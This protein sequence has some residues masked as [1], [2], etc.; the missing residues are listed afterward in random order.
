M[1]ISVVIPCY[2]SEKTIRSVVD[3]VVKTLLQRKEIE[4]EVILVNDC[5]PDNVWEEINLISRSNC[6][7]KGISFA[8]NFGQHSAL[9]AGYRKSTGDIIVSMDD[10]GQTPASEIFKLIDRVNEGA[11]VVYATYNHKKH[12]AFRNWGSK[13]NGKMCERLLGKPKGLMVTSYFAMKR[14]VADEICKYHNSYTYV[15]GLIFRTTKNI[16]TVPVSHRER[17]QGESGYSIKKLLS[18]WLN[19]FTAFSVKPLRIASL[20]GML[21]AIVGFWFLVYIVINKIISPFVPIGWTSIVATILLVGGI[22]L[23]T[24]G[25][26]GEYLGR[27]YICLNQAPQ[28]VVSE[29]TK[30]SKE[31]NLS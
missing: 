14:F 29:E 1:K 4:Y 26:I 16:D 11:D 22:I 31:D 27:V 12:S 2:G 8:K 21:F 23:F 19:G 25:I 15:I 17:I 18:L 20:F 28:Y 9:M 5:S 6:N 3:E 7:I 30:E 10:D 24:L 13:V